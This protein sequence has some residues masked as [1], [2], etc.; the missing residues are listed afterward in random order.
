MIIYPIANACK[1]NKLKLTKTFYCIFM[2]G[3]KPLLIKVHYLQKIS[4]Q[5]WKVKGNIF[6]P[7]EEIIKKNNCGKILIIIKD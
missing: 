2:G 5:V 1:Q 4:K 6:F 3:G 7:K